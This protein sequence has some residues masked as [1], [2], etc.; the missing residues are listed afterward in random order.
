MK[1][2][3]KNADCVFLTLLTFFLQQGALQWVPF[4]FSK[5]RDFQGIALQEAAGGDFLMLVSI[6]GENE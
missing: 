5:K 6:E 4:D 2:V 1:S 3:F